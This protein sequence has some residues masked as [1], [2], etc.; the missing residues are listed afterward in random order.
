M[1]CLVGV[2]VCLKWM[3]CENVKLFGLMVFVVVSICCCRVLVLV[4]VG[5]V[6][7]VNVIVCVRWGMKLKLFKIVV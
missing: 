7:V 4:V 5:I 2:F 1:N 3:V 6:S